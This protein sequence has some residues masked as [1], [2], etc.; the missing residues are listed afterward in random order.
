[1]RQRCYF[2]IGV[3]RSGTSALAGTFYR[4]TFG[5]YPLQML[6][7][8]PANEGNPKGFYEDREVVRLNDTILD[9]A[10]TWVLCENDVNFDHLLTDTRY[11]QQVREVLSRYTSECFCIKDP[12]LSLTLPVYIRV[13]QDMGVECHVVHVVRGEQAIRNSFQNRDNLTP[14]HAQKLIDKYRGAINVWGKRL[15]DVDWQTVSFERF[16]AEPITVF[17]RHFPTSRPI[18]INTLK[19][20]GKM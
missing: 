9:D 4:S 11:D 5:G 17:E 14:E 20:L 3:G 7:L 12:R 8:I 10:G 19:F 1:M 6:D 15:Q 13:L 18:L 2:L 16:M